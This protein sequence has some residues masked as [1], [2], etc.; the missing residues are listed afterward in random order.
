MPARVLYMG[1]VVLLT[2]DEWLPPS[3]SIPIPSTKEHKVGDA[4]DIFGLNG[5]QQFI[6]K[7]TN[8]SEIS[9]IL[10][11]Q[12]PVAPSWHISNIEVFYLVDPPP[13]LGGLVIDPVDFSIIA[14]WMQV[15]DEG[16]FTGLY[17]HRYI[18]PIV[19]SIRP[20]GEVQSWDSGWK[21]GQMNLA[22]ALDFG[23]PE[24]YATE[25]DKI[26]ESIGAGPQIIWVV[27]KSDQH[28]RDL[29]IGDFILEI[30]GE[31]VG[32]MADVH[33][34]SQAPES[35]V[36]V[37]RDHREME[38]VLHSRRVPEETSK[39]VSWAGAILQQCPNFAFECVTPEFMRTARDEGL[40]DIETSVYI[41]A[42]YNGSPA[43]GILHPVSWIVE[44]DGQKV[45]SI[46]GLL[47]VVSTLKGKDERG[48][49]V[50]V[51]LLDTRGII[52][53]EGVKL[54]TLFWPA[55]I[56]ELKGK[57]WVRTELE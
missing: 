15:K 12:N 46:G 43:T 2:V 40:T 25:I 7:R 44:I 26:A 42:V 51:K 16:Y 31:T 41:S 27:S 50:R 4:I 45:G 9:G 22:R 56:L 52:S 34:L 39:L 37:L 35:T 8:I 17:Y 33:V 1:L 28:S 57:N 49:Y 47:D 23:I 11:M 24:R 29:E 19:E 13:T 32:R 3:L 55:W 18:H 53:I 48:E 20:G 6:Q 54:N 36:M 5:Q 10:S 14:L 38:I 21:F 30:N